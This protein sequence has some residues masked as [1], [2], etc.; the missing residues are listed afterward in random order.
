MLRTFQTP[1]LFLMLLIACCGAYADK[2]DDYIRQKMA[3]QHI[4]GLSLAVLWDGKIVKVKGYGLANVELNAPST[5]QTL[6]QIQS[7]TKQFTAAAVMMLVEQGKIGLDEPVSRYLAG[8]PESWKPITVRHLLTHTSGIKDYINEPT[9]NLRLDVTEEEVYQATIPRPLNF[10]PGERFSYSN[11]NYHLLGMILHKVSGKPYGAFLQERIFEPLGMKDTRI[12]SLSDILPHRASG[13]RWDGKQLHNGDYISPTILG[14]AGGGILS[15]VLDLAKWDAALSGETLLKSSSLQQ[16]WTSGTL[17]DG[18]PTN[19]GF[20]WDLGE[21]SGHKSVSH[22]GGHVTGFT[23]F[24]TRFLKDRLTIVVL[25]NQLG[26]SDPA[27]IATGVA[28]YY[29]PDLL[30]PELKVTRLAPALLESYTGRYEIQNNVLGTVTTRNGRLYLSSE[31]DTW[32]LLPFSETTFFPT[33]PG[34]DPARKVR[35]TFQ[36]FHASTPRLIYTIEGREIKR[37]APYIGPLIHTL[38]P[39]SDPDPNRTRHVWAA[40][41]AMSQGGKAVAEA[42]AL[43]LGARKDFGEVPLPELAGLQ[44]LSFIATQDVAGR[45]IERHGGSV[46]RIIYY[47]LHTKLHTDKAS[48]YVL[49]Y[50]TAEGLVTDEDVVDD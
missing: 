46:T 22:G 9:Q 37:P 8:T 6:Y 35:L 2:V 32:E 25:T 38:K 19:Y 48:H 36:D 18:S 16:M 11:T 20:G 23:T 4:P 24:I 7:M 26:K 17:N 28:T 40:L 31:G 44:S 41:Q 34:L 12:L 1:V 3:H 15:T 50:L 30:G 47:K 33:D 45:G 43:S 5:P 14:Y 21:T 39:Q 13:Y 29:L 49:V 10:Q 27:A 42:P